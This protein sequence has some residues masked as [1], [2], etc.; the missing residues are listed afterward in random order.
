MAHILTMI[1]D[2]PPGGQ[3]AVRYDVSEGLTPDVA[4][5]ALQA[6]AAELQKAV[7]E[8]EVQRR[9]KISEV[10]EDLRNQDRQ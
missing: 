2:Q 1:I 5:A 6:V 8:A 9:I 7:I 3:I 10:P 4:L